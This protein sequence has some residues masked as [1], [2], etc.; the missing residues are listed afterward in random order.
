MQRLFIECS[1][2]H[3]GWAEWPQARGFNHDDV[4]ARARCGQC[5]SKSAVRAQLIYVPQAFALEGARTAEE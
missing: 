5:G 3:Q 2:G 1:C 4:V